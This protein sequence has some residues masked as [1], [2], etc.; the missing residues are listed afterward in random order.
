M[1]WDLLKL[2]LRFEAVSQLF[3]FQIA[4]D[5]AQEALIAIMQRLSDFRSD[6]KFPTW[7]IACP[8]WR[9]VMLE[10]AQVLKLT[11]TLKAKLPRMLE[12]HRA[13]IAALHKMIDVAS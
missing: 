13:I 4:E 8:G 11:D 10:M 3:E 9:P 6:S 12:E 1:N 2:S 7:A 5:C